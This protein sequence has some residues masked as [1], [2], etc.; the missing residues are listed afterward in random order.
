MVGSRCCPDHFY[1]A[2]NQISSFCF[3]YHGLPEILVSDNG[4]AFTSSKFETFVKRNGFRHIRV[5]PYHPASNGAAERAVQTLKDF[6]RKTEGDLD[7][8][9]ARFLFQYRLTP[10]SSMGISPAEL[11]FGRK[12]KITS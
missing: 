6:L 2:G 12:T 11:L 5:A 10:H 3:R 9:I 1:A 7:T 8:R 4:S